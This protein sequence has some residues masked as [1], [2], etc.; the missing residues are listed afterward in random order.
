MCLAPLLPS[1]YEG[2][3]PWSVT[4]CGVQ[5]GRYA[6]LCLGVLVLWVQLGVLVERGCWGR[7]SL[8]LKKYSVLPISVKYSDWVETEDENMLSSTVLV[9]TS[10]VYQGRED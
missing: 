7:V 9:N 4:D 1:P 8:G 2:S 6:S 5:L 10:V 3:F